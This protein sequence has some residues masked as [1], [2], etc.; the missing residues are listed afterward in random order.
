MSE[1]EQ[2]HIRYLE[3]HGEDE[4]IMLSHDE[5]V[6]VHVQDRVNGFKPIPNWIVKAAH[7]R[8]SGCKV[9]RKKYKQSDEGKSSNKKYRQSE[10]GKIA[11][12]RASARYYL[13]QKEMKRGT[14]I[15]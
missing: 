12:N 13:K 8:S 1:L 3:I 2:H 7:R 6:K 15:E 11:D 10:K 4:I 9:T 5:H 14:K